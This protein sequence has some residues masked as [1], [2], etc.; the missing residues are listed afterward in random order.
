MRIAVVT[1][2][3]YPTKSGVARSITDSILFLRQKYAIDFEVVC[4]KRGKFPEIENYKGIQIRKFP[5]ILHIARGYRIIKGILTHL[6]K[7]KYDLIHAH[8]F[9]YYPATVGFLASKLK[10]IPIIFTPHFHPPIYGIKRSVLFNLYNYTQGYFILKYANKVIAITNYEKMLLSSIS[11]RVDNIEVIPHPVDINKFKIKRVDKPEF[12]KEK[13]VLYISGLVPWKGADVLFNISRKILKRRKDVSF[14][15]IGRG[16]LKEKL[17]RIAKRISKENYVFLENLTDEEL[18]KW[19]NLANI[20]ALPS[21]YEAFGMVL[22]EAQACCTPCVSTLVG[23]I[24]EVVINGKTGLLVEYG[25][26]KGFEENIE[27]LLDN[28]KLAKQMGKAGRRHVEKNFEIT[29]VS[30]KLYRVYESLVE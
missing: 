21:Y 13:V 22:A 17:M 8:H 18:I 24:P 25:D 26:W 19:Y 1:T 27:Y 11:K 29:K 4:P 12:L 10:R 20:F 5:Q 28:P 9:G 15:F 23:G 2:M 7:N 16:P 14:V 30:Q 3:F 6:L